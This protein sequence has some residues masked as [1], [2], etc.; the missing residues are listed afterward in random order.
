MLNVNMS[1]EYNTDH[2]KI[3]PRAEDS[4]P[5]WLLAADNKNNNALLQQ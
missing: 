3:Y 2:Q 1:T 4:A 5:A